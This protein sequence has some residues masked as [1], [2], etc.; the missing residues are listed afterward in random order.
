MS[1]NKSKRAGRWNGI[2]ACIVVF[3]LCVALIG[4]AI[5]LT[6]KLL[7]KFTFE[8]TGYKFGE[9]RSLISG[10]FDKNTKKIEE[11]IDNPIQAADVKG[12]YDKINATLFLKDG[13]E[14]NTDKIYNAVFKEKDSQDADKNRQTV[15]N[16]LSVYGV[17]A[18]E[19]GIKA[20]DNENGEDSEG[21][22][23][24]EAQGD[25][26]VLDLLYDILENI[27]PEKLKAA[28]EED[29]KLQLLDK[30]IGAFISDLLMRILSDPDNSL[31]GEFGDTLAEY[32]ISLGEMV[33]LNQ[34]SFLSSPYNIEGVDTNVVMLKATASLKTKSTA[35]A[36]LE[37]FAESKNMPDILESIAR[38]FIKSNLPE[39]T[40]LTVTMGLSHD[41]GLKVNFNRMDDAKMNSLFS[42]I[43]KITK[44]DIQASINEGFSEA[45][46]SLYETINDTIDITR[47]LSADH[48]I[49]VPVFDMA[50][51]MTVNKQLE[52]QGGE[53]IRITEIMDILRSEIPSIKTHDFNN[54]Y[55]LD[56]DASEKDWIYVLDENWEQDAAGEWTYTGS[57]QYEGVVLTE[58][59]K[60]K[61]EDEFIHAL[62]R[63]YGLDESLTFDKV[64]ETFMGGNSSEESSDKDISEEGSDN[65]INGIIDM[66]NSDKLKDVLQNDAGGVVIND[67]MIAAIVNSQ[68]DTVL[69]DNNFGDAVKLAYVALTKEDVGQ[70][71]H[72]LLELGVFVEIGTLLGDAMGDNRLA[73]A[74]AGILPEKVLIKIYDVDITPELPE[75]EEY[76]G[77]KFG[78]ND[79]PD[80]TADHYIEILKNLAGFDT[81]K[82]NSVSAQVRDILDKMSS[83]IPVTLG[84]SSMD[85]P[86]IYE[87]LAYVLNG[88]LEEDEKI[89]KADLETSLKLLLKDEPE[90]QP[91]DKVKHENELNNEL[92]KYPL[93]D[94]G[95]TDGLESLRKMLDGDDNITIKELL[96][97]SE[98][99]KTIKAY[100]GADTNADIKAYISTE[101]PSLDGNMILALVW[102]KVDETLQNYGNA[103]PKISDLEILKEGDRD[104]IKITMSVVLKGFLSDDDS[105]VMKLLKKLIPTSTL[106]SIK[107]EITENS[108]SAAEI[109]I[110]NGNADTLLDLISK[111]DSAN[112]IDKIK[113]DIADSVKSAFDDLRKNTDIEIVEKGDSAE[114]L[115]PDIFTFADKMLCKQIEGEEKDF[116]TSKYDSN[117]NLFRAMRIILDNGNVDVGAF[118]EINKDGEANV[119]KNIKEAYYL[120]TNA[121]SFDALTEELDSGSTLNELF[122]LEKIEYGD[123]KK[124]TLPVV[125]LGGIFNKKM[126]G[127]KFADKIVSLEI[128]EENGNRTITAIVEIDDISSLAD[129][130][131][132]EIAS[133]ISQ[134]FYIKAVITDETAEFYINNFEYDDEENPLYLVMERLGTDIS[135]VIDEQGQSISQS[136]NEAFD[137]LNKNI[138]YESIKD[139]KI[140]LP[141][142]FGVLKT[143]IDA[144]KDNKDI[145]SEDLRAAIQGLYRKNEQSGA[146][147]FN[148][149]YDNVIDNAFDANGSYDLTTQIAGFILNHSQPLR[150]TDKNLGSFI[151]SK[152]T[153]D[154]GIT[155]LQFNILTAANTAQRTQFEKELIKDSN[156]PEN[157]TVI[158]ITAELEMD[159]IMGEM[160]GNGAE[161]VPESMLITFA[162]TVEDGNFEYKG[163]RL[164]DMDAKILGILLDI[165]GVKLETV[166]ANI[167]EKADIIQEPVTT[168]LK[169]AQNAK[170]TYE[171]T[172]DGED[173]KGVMQFAM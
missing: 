21:E 145:S 58:D 151:K 139:N 47:F 172:T 129:G 128:S 48:E 38:N 19:F 27:D 121:D 134:T 34:L 74:V 49:T 93:A 15:L 61:F 146:N 79:L 11:S 125:D 99:T 140:N 101:R 82:F 70:T 120:K 115:L 30:E 72:N 161:L 110:N 4:T 169:V 31:L 160:S 66:F 17:D 33:A 132:E 71:A 10:I 80:E 167:T 86:E 8:F 162:F 55:R 68:M 117:V 69:N 73:D 159:S 83:V 102:D 26:A 87:T 173:G 63:S 9:I 3:V 143:K 45:A 14:L 32:G 148:Y 109:L 104:F 44:K 119:I 85:L 147:A 67:R 136:A 114:M 152:M 2:V 113:V 141:D 155:I 62:Q 43:G 89:N 158:L 59:N 13:Y 1:N 94:D 40:F 95:E 41:V 130:V 103:E 25:S 111:F 77:L 156:I 164:N 150:V 92:S 98:L 135:G 28:D 35:L 170:V 144:I 91:F 29:F 37:G 131:N 97:V 75:G 78:Y 20:A 81:S 88:R 96:D 107:A 39:K 22:K 18:S 57:G 51:D 105:D 7:D 138:G 157:E 126:Q 142:I 36:F 46:K 54:W 16:M 12:F 5:G 118:K 84:E 76:L 112:N 154:N 171:N 124:S 42:L 56:K 137:S 165:V 108:D 116:A 23:T 122:D 133:L 123:A 127:S 50:L 163:F 153:A 64:I 52:E 106:I 90:V 65:E 149:D 53:K 166:N 24:D 168:A 100:K 6:N 60:V